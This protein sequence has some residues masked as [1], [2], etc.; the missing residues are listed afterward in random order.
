MLEFIPPILYLLFLVFVILRIRDREGTAESFYFASR[1]IG[2]RASIISIVATETSVATILIF[3]AVGYREDLAVLWLCA[4]YVVGRVIVA[5]FILGRIHSFQGV[6]LYGFLSSSRGTPVLSGV[7]LIAKYISGGVRFYMA[8]YAIDAL[9]GGG[10]AIWILVV[11][12]ITGLYSLTGGLKSVV[13]TDQIQGSILFL[14]GLWFCWRFFPADVRTLADIRFYVPATLAPVGSGSIFLFLGGLT[15]TLGSHGADQ[16]MLQRVFAVRDLS[17]ARRSLIL[18]GVA[19]TIVILLFAFAGLLMRRSMLPLDATSPLVSYIGQADPL[20]KGLF[21][22]LVLAA[23][24][25]TLDSAMHATGAVIKDLSARLL[26]ENRDSKADAVRRYSFYSLLLFVLSALLFIE[27]AKGSYKG[28]F[29]GL[30]MGSMNYVYGGLIGVLLT[31]V[32]ERRPVR[33]AAIVAA[34]V[35]GMAT[36]AFS[37]MNGLYWPLVTMLSA[38]MATGASLTAQRLMR[39]RSAS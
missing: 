21:L 36:T 23:S 18:S 4:G 37:E 26:A 7:Y 33:T 19:A 20:S 11:A 28:D 29:L 27:I 39:R 30:A 5:F 34:M 16:D 32:L 38:S 6:S 13:L 25:S 3:P 14:A 35:V 9:I 10:V 22:V 31:F 24:M 15:I 2:S 8:A 12:L 1:G 17:K